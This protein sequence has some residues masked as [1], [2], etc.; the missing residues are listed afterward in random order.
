MDI[1]TGGIATGLRV[2]GA[3]CDVQ[4]VRSWIAHRTLPGP[5]ESVGKS[6]E[7]AAGLAQAMSR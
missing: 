6:I 1:E 5:D 7:A 4:G 2:A 3:H